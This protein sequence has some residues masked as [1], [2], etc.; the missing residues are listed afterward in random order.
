ML[1]RSV[2]YL[3]LHRYTTEMEEMTTFL[4]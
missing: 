1:K 4:Y 3:V 2:A